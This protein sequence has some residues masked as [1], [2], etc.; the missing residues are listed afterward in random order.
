[1]NNQQIN[2]KTNKNAAPSK[3][4]VTTQK[5]N[6]FIQRYL[7]LINQTMFMK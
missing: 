1:M 4:L 3:T 6:T 7:K 2:I 5:N